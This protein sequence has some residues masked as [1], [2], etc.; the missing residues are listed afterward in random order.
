MVVR[1]KIRAGVVTYTEAK[2]IVLRTVT[3][4]IGEVRYDLKDN[5][6]KMTVIGFFDRFVEMRINDM[7]GGSRAEK[8]GQWCRRVRNGRYSSVLS[9]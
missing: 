5:F 8:H 3:P 4:Q 6:T 7:L 9:I 2:K 1:F